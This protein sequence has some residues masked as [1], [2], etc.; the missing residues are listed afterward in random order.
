MLPLPMKEYGNEENRMPEF[1]IWF[2]YF[3]T[4]MPPFLTLSFSIIFPWP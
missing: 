3:G 2:S 4:D 1:Y